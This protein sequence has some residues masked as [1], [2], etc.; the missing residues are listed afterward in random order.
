MLIASDDELYRVDE[1]WLGPDKFP[2][3]PWRATYRQYAVFTVLCLLIQ[4]AERQ[5][6]IALDV[7]SV[8]YGVALAVAGTRLLSRSLDHD[9]PAAAMAR[10]F[11]L[12]LTGPRTQTRTTGVAWR[13]SRMP[14]P[15]RRRRR[16]WD[17]L[18]PPVEH[19]APL[20][21]WW[22]QFRRSQFRRSQRRGRQ[23]ADAEN[24]STETSHSRG[25]V[26]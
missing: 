19:D 21:S 3:L 6:G 23:P 13:A 22:S 16:T 9:R 26:S 15:R 14:R 4:A 7:W 24:T 25:G 12:E 2:R 11:T 8:V 18:S 17:R 5:L 10:E 20:P 1:V